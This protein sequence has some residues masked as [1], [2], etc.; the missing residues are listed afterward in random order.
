[1]ARLVDLKRRASVEAVPSKPF[2]SCLQNGR[3]ECGRALVSF[4]RRAV[5]PTRE[6]PEDLL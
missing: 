3:I 1:M 5:E 2:W 6:G 4:G